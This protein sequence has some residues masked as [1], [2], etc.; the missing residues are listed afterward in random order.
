MLLNWKY[1]TLDR[2]CLGI[3]NASVQTWYEK[4]Q[5]QGQSSGSVDSPRGL[6]R[7]E[8]ER[9][10]WGDVARRLPLHRVHA[11]VAQPLA[12]VLTAV[13][14]SLTVGGERVRSEREE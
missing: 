3:N 4:K 13:L 1:R 10:P 11:S 5:N 8:V 14:V 12:P 6:P 9:R 7:R 2:F